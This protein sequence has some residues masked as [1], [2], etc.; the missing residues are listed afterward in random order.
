MLNYGLPL[1]DIRWSRS[2]FEGEG[3]VVGWNLYNG[4]L[5]FICLLACIDKP[6][7]RQGDRFPLGLV[8]CLEV[9]GTEYWGI[10]NDV[11]E[12]GRACC[13]TTLAQARERS[14]DDC[15]CPSTTWSCPSS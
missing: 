2:V 9:E 12:Q 14:T 1:L 11:S 3:L 13:S 10:T 15:G 4:I 6:I 8:A 7:R 5:M